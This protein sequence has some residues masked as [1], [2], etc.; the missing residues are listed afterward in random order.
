VEAR[1]YDSEI[2]VPKMQQEYKNTV[3]TSTHISKTPTQLPN[4]HTLQN[5][6]I[7]TLTHYKTHKNSEFPVD[8][9]PKLEIYIPELI[10]DIYQY[11][12][13]AYVTRHYTI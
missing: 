2:R 4:T 8:R 3:N 10:L 1:L 6:H 5:P 13:V 12:P 9:N 7:H 11:I